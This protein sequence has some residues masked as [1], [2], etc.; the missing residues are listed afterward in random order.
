MILRHVAL[1]HARRTLTPQSL[2]PLKRFVSSEV[3]SADASVQNSLDEVQAI[4]A[5][6]NSLTAAQAPPIDN[7]TPSPAQPAAVSAEA[8]E[9]YLLFKHRE[10]QFGAVGSVVAPHYQPHTLLSNPP[11]PSD[12]TLELL[13]ASEAHQGHATALWNP[14]NARYIHGI[15]QGT[16]IIAL[17]QTAAHLRR[18][19]KIVTEV[20][21]RGGLILFVG[22]RAGQDRCV[23]KAAQLA[24]GCHLFERWIPG[25]ITN[26]QQILG[27]CRTK[28][29]NEKDEEVPGFED[30][31]Y[32]RS[33]LK[34]DL[35]VCLNPM[36]N[37]VLL[38]ECGDHSIPTIGV[39]DT[40]ADPTWVT[41]P[42]PANDDSLRCI[43]VIGGVLG[44]AGEQGQK[45]RQQAAAR[46]IVTYPPASDLKPPAHTSSVASQL[47][48]TI[49]K[50][51]QEAALIDRT[52]SAEEPQE[53]ENK[54][55]L[56]D[57]RDEER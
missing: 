53:V 19:A 21:R 6:I 4:A 49:E 56:E 39:I 24:Q 8:A 15:R 41:Y 17:D 35:V 51:R 34:P 14:A 55:D 22:T 28:V 33:V 31:L 46:G 44:R 54:D 42:I 40:D 38:R 37:Y 48:Q 50:R 43:Q 1:R 25:S 5:H 26:G 16:H 12:V 11:S 57:S 27:K 32:D 9:S 10:S 45:L 7:L 36:E 29:V 52:M 3:E 23:V 20:A 47:E 13:L 18:A 30:Q 2:R